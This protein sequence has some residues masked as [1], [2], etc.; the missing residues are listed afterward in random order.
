MARNIADSITLWQITMRTRAYV[1]VFQ[2]VQE[3]AIRV[4]SLLYKFI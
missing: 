4:H 3:E 2:E 1:E